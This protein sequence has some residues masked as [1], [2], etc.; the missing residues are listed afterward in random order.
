MCKHY[1]RIKQR[2]IVLEIPVYN[3]YENMGNWLLTK[4]AQ[5]ANIYHHIHDHDS[6]QK[7]SKNIQFMVFCK[8]PFSLK[9]LFSQ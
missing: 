8:K 6:L 9:S 4:L 3:K 1:K 7:Q 5:S 2:N